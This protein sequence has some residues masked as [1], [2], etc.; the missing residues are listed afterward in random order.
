M[1]FSKK[2]PTCGV[3]HPQFKIELTSEEWATWHN[4]PKTRGGVGTCFLTGI[5]VGWA[6]FAAGDYLGAGE[7][8]VGVIYPPV[9]GLL[10]ASVLIGFLAGFSLAHHFDKQWIRYDR[11]KE[12]ILSRYAQGASLREVGDAGSWNAKYVLVSP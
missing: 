8:A 12:K 4:K 6:F 2:C 7:W 5:G 1:E 3:S 9:L 10:I 11:A